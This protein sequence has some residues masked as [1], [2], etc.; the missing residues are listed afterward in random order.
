MKINKVEETALQAIC[1][2]LGDTNEGLTGSEISRLLT[3][4][5][6]PDVSPTATKRYRLFEALKSK[7]E[8][9]NCGNNIFAFIMK[10][11]DPIRYTQSSETF[12]NRRDKMNTVLAF[13]GFKLGE[14]GQ[15]YTTQQASTLSE[16]QKRASRLKKQ[17]TDRNVHYDVLKF[18]RAELL[19]ENY[20]HAVFEATKSVA[21]KIREKTGLTIDGAELIDRVFGIST[22]LLAIN[23]LQTE[24]EQTEQKGFSNLIK[25]LFGVFRNV[26][27]HIPKIK[28]PIKEQD[29][30]DLLSLVSYI[31]RRLDDAVVIKK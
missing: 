11:M 30:L 27:A 31:H 3:Q 6:I 7:Q 10:A 24:T 17:L 20:F 5:N 29:A 28:W 12:S 13:L 9:D 4:L 2:I 26:T 16:A 18:C 21:D 1:D 22:P 8:H 14:N 19:E 25:G 15:M 23:T